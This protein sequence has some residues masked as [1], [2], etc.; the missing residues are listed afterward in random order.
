MLSIYPIKEIEEA[1]FFSEINEK[2]KV[3]AF[4]LEGKPKY[5]LMNWKHYEEITE[6]LEILAD[7]ATLKSIKNG[8]DD[9]K[10]KRLTSLDDFENEII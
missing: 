9:I 7:D 10:N 3:L 6:T 5:A 4:T 2:N 1:R 8:L